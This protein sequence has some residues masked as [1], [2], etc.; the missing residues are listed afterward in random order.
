MCS[1]YSETTSI[2]LDGCSKTFTYQYLLMYS[3]SCL[4]Q[5]DEP[6]DSTIELSKVQSVKVGELKVC[7]CNIKSYPFSTSDNP[8]AWCLTGCGG[9]SV[10][11][12][13]GGG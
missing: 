6:D 2:E 9:G 11:V 3:L 4:L 10:G 5:K 7:S 13:P 12:G 1:G 8:I